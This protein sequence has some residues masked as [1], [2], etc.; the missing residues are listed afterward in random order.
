MNPDNR[1]LVRVVTPLG[2]AV[3]DRAEAVAMWT[4]MGEIEVLPGHAPTVVVLEPGEL[5]VWDGTGQARIFAGGAG[6]ARIEGGAVTIFSDMA[7]DM[8]G[9]ELDQAEEAKRRA[10]IAVS[11]AAHLTADEREAADLAMQESVVKVQ[12]LLRRKDRGAGGSTLR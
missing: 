10:E 11:D 4:A 3:D 2:V 12:I 5:R 7:D 1:L 8:A 6:F 9:I